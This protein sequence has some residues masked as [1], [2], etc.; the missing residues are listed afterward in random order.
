MTFDKLKHKRQISQTN[1][2]LF[3]RL[4]ITGAARGLGRELALRFG[5]LGAKVACVDMDEDGNHETAKMI[6]S[7]GGEAASYKCDVSNRDQ[8]KAMHARVRDELGQVDMLI[9]NAGLVWGNAF[10][11]PTKDQFIIDMINVN[12][13]GQIWVSRPPPAGHAVVAFFTI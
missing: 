13:M 2:H 4:Q 11:D 1:D 9:N 8:I 10:V 12:L 7:D 5:M 3:Y 6:K